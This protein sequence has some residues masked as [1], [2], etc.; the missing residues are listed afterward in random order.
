MK[1]LLPL[2][3]SC[4]VGLSSAQ[5]IQLNYNT[6]S[7]KDV[8]VEL[9]A[10]TGFSFSYAENVIADKTVDFIGNITNLEAFLE[11]LSSQTGLLFEKV[12][13]HKLL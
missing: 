3:F 8:L 6:A 5:E 11:T 9:Q 1:K 13:I 2:L 4:I 10:K 7:L 12:S